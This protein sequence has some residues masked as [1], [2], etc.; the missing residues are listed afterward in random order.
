MTDLLPA[1]AERLLVVLKRH[2]THPEM[3][4]DGVVQELHED[5]DVCAREALAFVAERLPK[6]PADVIAMMPPGTVVCEEPWN[7][8]LL[9]FL[10]DLRGRLGVKG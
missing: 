1:L 3:M 6:A 10:R 2:W 7:G 8:S 4:A 9:I 5:A